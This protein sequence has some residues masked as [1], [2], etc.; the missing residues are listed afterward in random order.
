MTLPSL[1]VALAVATHAADAT[2]RDVGAEAEALVLELLGAA[3]DDVLDLAWVEDHV[4]PGPSGW[5]PRAFEA[6][7]RLTV[8]GSS[9]RGLLARSP[10]PAHVAVGDGPIRVVLDGLPLLSVVLRDGPEGLRVAGIEP[11]TCVGCDERTRFAMDLVADVRRRGSLAPRLVPGLDLDV[12]TWLGLNPPL[13][14]SRWV[15]A[16]GTYLQGDAT[17]AD[18]I[19]GAVVFGVEDDRVRLRYADGTEDHWRLTWSEGLGWRVAYEALAPTS[20]L[21]LDA[22]EVPSWR[23]S[24]DARRHGLETWRPAGVPTVDGAGRRLGEAA[25]GAGFVALDDLVVIASLSLDR[26]MSAMFRVE[27]ASGEVLAR[28]PL[29]VEDDRRV[30]RPVEGWATR[31]PFALRR[32]GRR[33]AVGTPVGVVE[34]DLDAGTTRVVRDA[35]ATVTA[36]AWTPDGHLAFALADG[37]V[38][39]GATSLKP[40]VGGAPIALDVGA[41]GV[42]WVTASGWVVTLDGPEGSGAPRARRACEPTAVG[43]DLRARDGTW[44]VAC[45]PGAT[46]GHVRIPWYDGEAEAYGDTGQPGPAAVGWSEDGDRYV[47]ARPGGGLVVWNDRAE[48]AEAAF[49]QETMQGAAFSADGAHLLGVS[50]KGDVMWWHLPT[51]RRLHGVVRRVGGPR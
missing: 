7:S 44:I 26:T 18:R 10:G 14:E 38:E 22:D 34:V 5:T 43:A 45:G 27:P 17:V 24:E 32:D 37:T 30:L 16:L 21:R 9:I 28:V 42:S 8:P 3:R 39:V 31:W 12:A 11:T 25:V 15:A 23:R 41:H 29:P 19:G 46:A 4:D 49:G 13:R 33:A 6:W 51:A 36:L 48:R 20:P 47:V 1:V 50:T 2:E 35:G 40:S